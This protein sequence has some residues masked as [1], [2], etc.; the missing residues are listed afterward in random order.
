MAKDLKIQK[1]KGY[2]KQKV[3]ELLDS[4]K[5]EENDNVD[6]EKVNII[7]VMNESFADLSEIY[8]ID[9]SADNM[10]FYHSLK[11]RKNTVVGKM[12]S[13]QYGGG[14]ANV[15]YEFLT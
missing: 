6:E 8:N 11:N 2:N 14:T 10:P 12:H 7:I 3:K 9:S 1:P 4:Y 15:E 5:V 13:S